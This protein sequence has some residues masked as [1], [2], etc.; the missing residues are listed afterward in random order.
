MTNANRLSTVKNV[1]QIYAVEEDRVTETGQHD[2]LVVEGGK[3]A[4]PYEAQSNVV[5]HRLTWSLILLK[6]PIGFSSLIGAV[7]KT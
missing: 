7:Q 4:E 2:Q 1:D 5:V 3:Y 6:A